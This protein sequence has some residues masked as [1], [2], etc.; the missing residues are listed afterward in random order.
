MATAPGSTQGVCFKTQIWF[1][2]EVV[3]LQ[4]RLT[5]QAI[6]EWRPDVVVGQPLTLGVALGAE[7]CEVPL[8]VMGFCT[9][10]WP[11]PDDRARRLPPEVESRL[12]WRATSMHDSSN[13]ARTAFGMPTHEYDESGFTFVGDVHMLRTVATFEPRRSSLLL[14]TSFVG[15]CLWEPPAIDTELAEFLERSTGQVVYVQPGRFFDSPSFWPSV[16][17]A[18]GGSRTIRVVASIGRMDD[19]PGALPSNF[20]VRPHVPQSQALRSANVVVASATT[21]AVL[22]AISAGVPLVLMPAGGEQPDVAE[23]CQHGQ[24]AR[25]LA[26]EVTTS[27]AICDGVAHVLADAAAQDRI[28]R[29]ATEFSAVDGFSLAATSVENTPEFWTLKDRKRDVAQ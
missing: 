8:A 9:Y 6:K 25:V 1:Q 22:G 7:R 19:N 10:L 23:L 15:A 4:A 29:L 11:L 2:H 20:F 3:A 27:A 13:A 21:T 14:N 16:K 24:I 5:I 18:F 26:P 12:R 28:R 17:S